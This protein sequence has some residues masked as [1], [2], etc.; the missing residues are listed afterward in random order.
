MGKLVDGQ[1][2]T[3]WYDTEATGGRFVRSTTTFRDAVTRD[4][5]SGFPAVAGR[6]HLYVSYACP[7]A[8]RTLIVRAL[9]KLDAAIGVSAVE[10]LML[11]DGWEFSAALPDHAAGRRFA[12]D[13]YTDA[14]PHFT[15][16]VTVPILW[17]TER[18]TIVNN[19]S[20]DIIRMLNTEF[21]DLA[22]PA[23]IDL[24]PE[25]L[26]AEI[27]TVNADVYDRVNNGVYKCG[28]ATTQAAYDAAVSALFACL[29]G[30]EA[31]LQGRTWL[32]GERLTEADIRLF[33]TLVRF[34]PVYHGHFK[35]NRNRIVDMPN[36][37]RHTRRVYQLAS[38]ADTVQFDTIRTHYYSSHRSVNPSGI[39]P[40]GPSLD[41][42]AAL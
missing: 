28:F 31:R 22:D 42:L 6:Y 12:R 19:E 37:W 5:R 9:K 30:L 23:A 41:L 26:R 32:V 4:G 27:D 2:T 16:R 36:L 33:T 39:V 17:D 40:A 20:A 15:G 35:C 34:D 24:Y 21:A 18:S 13:I 3:Q 1:W 11:D 38:V 7:W 8:H 29:D 10:A 25:P 14:D